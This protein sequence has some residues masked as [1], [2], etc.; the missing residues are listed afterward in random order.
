MVFK[1]EIEDFHDF[2]LTGNTVNDMYLVTKLNEYYV[3]Q[4]NPDLYILTWCFFSKKFPLIYSEGT[5][6][7]L[8]LETELCPILSA[9]VLDETL[10]APE[11]RIWTLPKTQ[12][13]GILEGFPDSL[14]TEYGFQVLYFKGMSLDSN[15]QPYPLGSSRCSD[16]SGTHPFFPDLNAGSL[17]ENRYK[18]FLQWLA[19]QTKPAT[20]KTILTIAQLKKIRF[21][22]IYAGY[23]FYF[24]IKEIRINMLVDGLSLAEIDVY[25]V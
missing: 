14:G 23:G 20:F 8:Q 2:P 9:R 19:Y 6:P 10:C 24:L 18:E 21:Q 5:E 13:A 3:Y 4:Y 1:G 15:A 12:Q 16:Y 22:Q 7:F 11:Y 17:F 25:T